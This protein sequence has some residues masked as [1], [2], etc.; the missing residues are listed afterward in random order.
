LDWELLLPKISIVLASSNQGKIQE[1]QEALN[2]FNIE[3]IPQSAFGIR[4]VEETASTFVENALLKARHAA[5]IAQLPALADD[6]GLVVEVLA[7]A[8]GIYSARYAGPKAD[9]ADNINKLLEQMQDVPEEKRSAYFYCALILISHPLDPAP[10]IGIGKWHG[11]VLEK[12]RG[13]AGFGYDP[14][15][16]LSEEKK[17][18]AELTLD[19]KNKISHRGQALSA[20][21]KQLTEK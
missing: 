4:D 2:H 20:L 9:A 7:G 13:D 1:L 12:P 17:T 18:A 3:L 15:F 5:S 11:V 14:I 19:T 8:P 21:V 16:Y 10:K 6:S